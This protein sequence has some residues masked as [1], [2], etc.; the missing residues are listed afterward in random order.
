MN[1]HWKVDEYRF[2]QSEIP[3]LVKEGAIEEC[4]SKPK[5]VSPIKTVIKKSGGFRLII[6]LHHLNGFVNT[7][8]FQYDSVSKISDIL[9][10][11]DEFITFDLKSGFYHVYEGV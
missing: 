4:A 7:P 8:K 3:K 1:P 10:P 9:A 11:N 6:D 2:L 5:W